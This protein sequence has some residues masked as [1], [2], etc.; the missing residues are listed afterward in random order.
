M[1]YGQTDVPA[2]A[3]NVVA[4]A[5]GY[6]HNIALRADGIVATWGWD[7]PVPSDATNVVRGC[8]GLAALPRTAGRRV[9]DCLGR[10][11]VW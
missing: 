10:Q 11:Y 1:L 3:M 2:L 4:I 6:Y 9:G 8:G 7:L 5:A